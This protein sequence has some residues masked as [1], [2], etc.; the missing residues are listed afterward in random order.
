MRRNPNIYHNKHQT[1]PNHLG[2][3]KQ[4]VIHPPLG[5]PGMVEPLNVLH[6]LSLTLEL[7]TFSTSFSH[8]FMQMLSLMQMSPQMLK[9]LSFTAFEHDSSFSALAPQVSPIQRV[10]HVL[11]GT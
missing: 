2:M 11:S 9:C 7:F 3:V 6:L 5:A 8:S 4:D 10:C 1:P